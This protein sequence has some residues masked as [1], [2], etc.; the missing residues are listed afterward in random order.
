MNFTQTNVIN[1]TI[2]YMDIFC[3]LKK[4]KAWC[5]KFV[6]RFIESA[7]TN[8]DTDRIAGAL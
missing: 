3:G 6:D 5:D 1:K 4:N 2:T 7:Y 8:F